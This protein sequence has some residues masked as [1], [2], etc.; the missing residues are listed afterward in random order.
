MD[1]HAYLIMAYN[2]PKQLLSLIG[3][4]DDPRNDIY[5]HIDKDAD[6]P[7]E[8]FTSCTSKAILTLV[9][10][11]SVRWAHYS[12]VEAELQLL[13]SATEH[14]KYLY[15]HLLS[16]MDLPLKSQD[17]IHDYFRDKNTEFIGI[18]PHESKYNLR[19]VISKYPLLKYK[20]YRSS[21]I[22]K[23]LS[24]AMASIQMMLY[25]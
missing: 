3:L 2:N 13:H 20:R 12:Q 14:D 9:P 10:R 18:V 15:Y 7:M 6:F 11:V 24:E 5:V 22:L 23:L 16:G 17:Y 8:I 4:L 21:T 1:K 25:S 19:H